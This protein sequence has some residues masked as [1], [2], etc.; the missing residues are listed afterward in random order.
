MAF[1]RRLLT[2]GEE[3]VVEVHPHW[4]YTG[5]AIPSVVVA[6]AI[7][8]A[9]GVEWASAPKAVHDALLVLLGLV[10]VWAA[11]RVASWRTIT[12]VL[13]NLRLVSRRGVLARRGLD[14]RLERMNEIS[15]HQSLVG[16]IL[17]TG[18]LLVEVGGE[19]GVVIFDHMRRPAALASVV[20]EQLAGRRRPVQS[21]EPAVSPAPDSYATRAG[22]SVESP[23]PAI[24]GPFED[25]PP[26]G[27][28]SRQGA[29]GSDVPRSPTV[30]KLIEL[31]ELRRRGILSEA[32]FAAKKAE[33][34]G[35]L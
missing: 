3:V 11:V 6:A 29:S 32:E 1:P 13:T 20:H 26:G 14:I 34:L 10:L 15:Y 5:W 25:T 2:E 18:E 35:E 4:S 7:V 33:L 21:S 24:R 12:V 8:I 31:D 9:Q 27:T 23:G 22:S 28:L 19:T 17:G 16:R 30:Q